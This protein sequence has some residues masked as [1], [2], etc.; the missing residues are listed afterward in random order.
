MNRFNAAA[1]QRMSRGRPYPVPAPRRLG[2]SSNEYNPSEEYNPSGRRG[3]SSNEYNPSEEY[4]P[5]GR[6]GPSSN[7]YN[8]SEE[9]YTENSSDSVWES[10]EDIERRELIEEQAQITPYVEP[11][12]FKFDCSI[13]CETYTEKENQVTSFFKP[14]CQCNYI[15]M[16]FKCVIKL[17]SENGGNPGPNAKIKCPFCNVHIKLWEAYTD[18]TVIH[19]KFFRKRNLFTPEK[20]ADHWRYLHTE[21]TSAEGQPEISS[22]PQNRS[23]EMEDM[24]IRYTEVVDSL[25]EANKEITNVRNNLTETQSELTAERLKNTDL[26]NSLDS[27]KKELSDLQTKVNRNN[28]EKIENLELDVAQLSADRNTMQAEISKLQEEN[29]LLKQ[30]NQNTLNEHRHVQFQKIIKHSLKDLY[31]KQFYE[32]EER[33]FSIQN[34]IYEPANLRFHSTSTSTPSTSSSS[35]EKNV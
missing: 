26:S 16:C 27:A 14:T 31:K 1:E 28:L 21:L 22:P 29:R 3:P 4:N 15:C 5:S 8:P 33:I 17:Y 18:T 13:C 20:L 12:T 2:P 24:C 23:E 19:C 30:Q 35:N 32:L 10:Y 11:R 7:E 9:Y 25:E 34:A 6:R